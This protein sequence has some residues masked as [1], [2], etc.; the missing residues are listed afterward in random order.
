MQNAETTL[1][2]SDKTTVKYFLTSAELYENAML[3]S[4]VVRVYKSRVN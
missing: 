3:F 2:H 4:G 1:N